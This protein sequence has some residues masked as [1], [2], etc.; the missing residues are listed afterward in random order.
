[1]KKLFLFT[2]Y[3]AENSNWG[4][5]QCRASGS[6][7]ERIRITFPDPVIKTMPIHNNGSIIKRMSSP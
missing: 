7:S 4:Y 6:G 3:N 1:M 5:I 2:Q